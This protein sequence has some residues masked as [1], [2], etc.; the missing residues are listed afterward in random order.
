MNG[1]QLMLTCVLVRVYKQPPNCAPERERQEALAEHG[2]A[3]RRDARGRTT[4]FQFREPM[5]MRPLKVANN[6]RT[7][8][9]IW[10]EWE[11]GI[12]GNMPA[13]L[14]PDK[15]KGEDTFKYSRRLPIYLL[16]ERTI[17]IKKK[18]PAEA[19][20]L[21][22]LHFPNMSMGKLATEI[23]NRELAGTMP[24]ALADPLH[25]LALKR[26]PTKKRA[27][28]TATGANKRANN[29]RNMQQFYPS[30]ESN[31]TRN[32]NNVTRGII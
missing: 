15:N 5:D 19:F 24:E 16:L 11:H 26:K 20:R 9:M 12:G 23:K 10:Q 32:T 13:K 21:I 17:N 6:V 2:L 4:V 30:V 29:N 28:P 25:P 18:L 7:V 22:E 31:K 8:G 1:L 14:F 3:E 27:A